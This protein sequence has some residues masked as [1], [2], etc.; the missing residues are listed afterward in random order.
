[1]TARRTAAVLGRIGADSPN[2]SLQPAERAF[3][4]AAGQIR[5]GQ[6]VALDGSVL[7]VRFAAFLT[8]IPELAITTTSLDIAILLLETSSHTVSLLG[9]EL[10]RGSRSIIGQ[11]DPPPRNVDLGF[12]SGHS[13]TESAGLM[14]RDFAVAAG[15]RNLAGHCKRT[16]GFVDSHR[17]GSFG[18]YISVPAPALG[19]L[20]VISNVSRSRDEA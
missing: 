8:D 18:P 16:L 20:Y 6:S 4:L 2:R 13:F 9:G 5:R 7:C 12:F 17:I 3:E 1:M 19:S 14:D 10:D 15:K 11:P